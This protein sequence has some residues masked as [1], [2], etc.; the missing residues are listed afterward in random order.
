[1]VEKNMETSWREF[2]GKIISDPH[3]QQRILE[4]L[5]ISSMTLRRWVNG[6]THPRPQN[7]RL[8]LSAIP[9]QRRQMLALLIKEF[10]YLDESSELREENF[11]MSA[12]FYA[13]VMNTYVSVSQY[14]R[15]VTIS[16]LLLQHM[17]KHLDPYSD[18]M[19]ICIAQCVPPTQGQKVRSARIMTGR[20]TPPWSNY[21]EHYPQFMG[22]ESM[23]G[24]AIS[25]GHLAIVRTR[26]EGLRSFA[27]DHI[28]GVES[29][30]AV[31]I[32]L[33]N[34]TAGGVYI[35]STQIDHFTHKH[36]SLIQKYIELMC[37][38]FEKEDFYLLSDIALGV[39]P[40]REQQLP[41]L[42]TFQQR[43]TQQMV[44]AAQKQE[45]I[46]RPQAERIVWQQL[47][48]ELLHIVDR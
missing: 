41:C 48:A 10:P 9:Q 27:L 14:L 36:L 7:L 22:I 29:A 16:D 19:F 47:E 38:S 25:S 46:T 30:V 34:Q 11:I 37:L 18:G 4:A 5:N 35:A 26:A 13:Q 3:E 43:V 8:L 31:P 28:G 39:M 20:G 15:S 1:V 45:P 24:Y 12:E 32:V 21:V 44:S 33:A 23:V 6:E 42:V 2:L 40:T 17:L